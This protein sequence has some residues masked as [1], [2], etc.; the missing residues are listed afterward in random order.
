MVYFSCY[1]LYAQCLS[2]PRKVGDK[3]WEPF[4]SM[5]KC[6]KCG[7]EKS[8]ELFDKGARYKLGRTGACKACR[9]E[10]GKSLVASK[11]AYRVWANLR[12][13]CNSP[14]HTDYKNYGGRGVTFDPRWD[15][16]DAFWED[17]GATYKKGLSLDRIDNS[18]NYCKENCRWA[19][20]KEQAANTR[21]NVL[22][23]YYGEKLTLSEI[24]RRTKIS[25]QTLRYNVV[26]RGRE[27]YS[28]IRAKNALLPEQ[29]N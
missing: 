12:Q 17:M 28:V 7:E 26:I 2:S 21:R 18:G 27:L 3:L 29:P 1:Q 25:L 22:F 13:R 16:Y 8:L 5:K 14:S 10:Q 9:L 20:A 24:A 4:S 11:P 6:N 15:T 19:T 23:E